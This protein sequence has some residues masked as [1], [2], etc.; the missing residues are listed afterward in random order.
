VSDEPSTHHS[1]ELS[2]AL[3]EFATEH[4]T[5]AVLTGAEVRGRA[6]R[7]A[8]RRRAGTL[9]AG[10]AALALVALA[11]NPDSSQEGTQSRLPA[12]TPAVPSRPSPPAT[13]GAASPALPVAGTID[14]SRRTLT[15]G[16]RVMPIT[17]GLADS[18]RFAGPLSVFKR[19]DMKALAVADPTAGARESAEISLAVELRDTNDEPVFVGLPL[20]YGKDG[21]TYGTKGGWIGLDQADAKWLYTSMKIGSLLS[22]TDTG[23]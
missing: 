12:A 6:V 2:T 17:S 21:T 8:R 7:R 11:L 14:I 15:V 13:S 1:A 22:V 5:P 3:R 16:S 19:Y 10:A 23:S 20:A 9:A 4:E 18:R